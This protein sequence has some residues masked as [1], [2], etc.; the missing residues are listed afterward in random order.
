MIAGGA[1]AAA[2]QPAPADIVAFP[3]AA[4]IAEASQRFRIPVAWI[5][6]VICAESFGEVHAR[7]LKGAMGLM[8]IMPETW[9]GLRQRYG[10]GVDP[11]DAHDNII[12]GTGYLRELLDRYG[13]PAFLAA[14]NA[15]PVRLEAYLITGQQLPPETRF[16]LAR[17]VSI[18]DG[19]TPHDG[20]IAASIARS[21]AYASPFLLPTAKRP[22]DNPPA[23][24]LPSANPSNP[25]FAAGS[26]ALTPISGDIFPFR[27]RAW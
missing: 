1:A 10:L 11:Y 23:L 19:G 16:Y 3:F 7:S 5:R 2:V 18:L 20:A 21:R 4:S 6:A 12:A 8:Q 27:L 25:R 14:Y 13:A 9:N 26:A 24:V 17:L 15:G 22:A